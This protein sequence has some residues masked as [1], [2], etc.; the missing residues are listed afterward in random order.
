MT[1]EK[2]N[3]PVAP[4]GEEAKEGGRMNENTAIHNDTL[5]A[6][7]KV[8][9]LDEEYLTEVIVYAVMMYKA[10]TGKLRITRKE[11]D[12]IV[13]TTKKIWKQHTREP[14]TGNYLD[15]L[16]LLND[17]LGEIV[18]TAIKEMEAKE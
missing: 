15:R 6:W 14:Y 8:E 1:E 5:N 4:I 13:E 7:C 2:N 9:F 16:Y 12:K 17:V 10:H 11:H 3:S 18:E